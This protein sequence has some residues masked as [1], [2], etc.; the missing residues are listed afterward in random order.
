MAIVGKPDWTH[1]PQL[2]EVNEIGFD[3]LARSTFFQNNLM[4]LVPEL[5][6][7]AFALDTSVAEVKNML[8]LGKHIARL[9]YDCYNWDEECLKKTSE[10]MGCD[11]QLISP[12]Q[13]KCKIDQKDFPL[14]ERQPFSF[15]DGK[16]CIG[17]NTFPDAFNFSFAFTLNDLKRD[18]DLYAQMIRSRTPQ[19]GPFITSL[20]ASKTILILLSDPSLRKRFLG[21]ENK[22]KDSI[23]PAFSLD[24]HADYVRIRGTW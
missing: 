20:I 14:L 12:S 4:R 16:A 13:Y 18:Q 5:K 9:Q 7:K 2:L 8:R 21:S 19:Y 1:P 22:L 6:E 10:S 3:G 15:K 23:L 24:G 11:L 17:K